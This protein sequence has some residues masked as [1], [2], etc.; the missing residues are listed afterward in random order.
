MKLKL[1]KNDL[2]LMWLVHQYIWPLCLLFAAVNCGGWWFS[3]IKLPGGLIGVGTILAVAY[4]AGFKMYYRSGRKWLFYIG[5][6]LPAIIAVT[7]L[8]VGIGVRGFPVLQ[9]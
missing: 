4:E 7:L 9:P 3:G 6:L 1:S 8:L 2:R 5:Y